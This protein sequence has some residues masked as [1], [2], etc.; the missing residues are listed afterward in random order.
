MQAEFDKLLKTVTGISGEVAKALAGNKSSCTR[1]RNAMQEIKTQAQ[2]LR[3][4][5]LAKA[6]E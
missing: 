6:K 2:D 4:A 5:A 1:V 3:I